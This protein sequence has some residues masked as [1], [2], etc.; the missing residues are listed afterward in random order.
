MRI[1]LKKYTQQK[2]NSIK[3]EIKERKRGTH[4]VIDVCVVAIGSDRFPA[5][6]VCESLEGLQLL[7]FDFV[8]HVLGD[9]DGAVL[10]KLMLIAL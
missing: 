7:S 8:Q 2:G 3:K 5:H 1:F 6:L 4:L 9:Q 10:L